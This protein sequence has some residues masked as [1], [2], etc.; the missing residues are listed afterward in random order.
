MSLLIEKTTTI[1]DI[2]SLK[3]NMVMLE[4]QYLKDNTNMHLQIDFYGKNNVLYLEDGI[5]MNDVEI[6]FKGDNALVYLAK[7]CHHYNMHIAV[8]DG[9]VVYCGRNTY[10]NP[11]YRMSIQAYEKQNVI[12]GNDT[13]F[14]FDIQICTSDA[15]KIYDYSGER[16]NLP[17]SVL[18]GDHVWVG[19]NS[20]ILKGT[21]IGSG[22]IVGAHSTVAG[23]MRVY[24]N[25]IVAG[26]PARIIKENIFFTKESVIWEDYEQTLHRDGDEYIYQDRKESLGL[27]EIDILLKSKTTP[28]E[29]LDVINKQIV[30]YSEKNRFSLIKH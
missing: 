23:G 10:I 16:I 25:S 18:I 13:L 21:V 17:E 24:S 3:E 22:A 7:N 30:C 27:E 5:D 4:E 15:H 11:D 12:I 28:K 2:R 14:S 26:N 20:I 29:K 19:Q 1:S 8:S 9:G 6:K